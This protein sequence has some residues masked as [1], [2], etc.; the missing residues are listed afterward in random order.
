MEPANLESL[1]V[2]LDESNFSCA[3]IT[4]ETVVLIKISMP[5]IICHLLKSNGE[6]DEKNK[7]RRATKALQLNVE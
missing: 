7:Q 4:P 2:P 3:T 1:H 6:K 5:E